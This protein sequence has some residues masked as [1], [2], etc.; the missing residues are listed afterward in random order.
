MMLNGQEKNAPI[1]G[2]LFFLISKTLY[3]TW[4]LRITAIGGQETRQFFDP[5]NE[6]FRFQ[7]IS[8]GMSF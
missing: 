5:P 3:I 6:Y 8:R 4:T 1:C 2:N 7:V